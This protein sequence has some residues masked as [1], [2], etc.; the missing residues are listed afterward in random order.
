MNPAR[1]TT[2]ATATAV[3][4]ATAGTLLTL[5][6]ASA[7]TT[8]A[9]PVFKR[10]FFA[11][12]S[13]SGTPKK[14]DCDS[15]VD[16]NWGTKAPASGLPSNN[17]GVRWTVTRDFGSGGP[18]TF[19]ASGLDGIRVYLDPGTDNA[20]KIDLWKN[21]S[22]TVS[23]TVNVTVP[24]G[25]HTL[26]IDYVNW[27]GSAKV[28]FGYTP[29]TSATADKVKPLAPTG[30]SVTYDETTGEAELTWA[31]N[32]EM[33]LAGYK[34]YRRT[35]DTWTR[36][37]TTTAT[38]YTDTPPKNGDTYYYEVRA[39]DKA[40]N[41][42]AGST[43]KAVTTVKATAD[44][45]APSAPAGVEENWGVGPVDTVTLSWDGN[46]ESDLAGYRVYR[47]TSQPVVPTA[48]NLIGTPSSAS[49]ADTPARTGDWYYYVVT[50]V[51]THGNE[52]A[53]SGTAGFET[54][55]DTAPTF[56]P[57][58]LT[59]TSGDTAVT[60]TW[61]WNRDQ[62]ADLENFRV[63][64]DGAYIGD[65]TGEFVDHDVDVDATYTYY[66]RAED[67]DGNLGP[68]SASV[69]VQHLGDRTPPGAVTGLV[70]TSAENGILL[71]WDDST[72]DDF[73][74]YE[75][76][77][78]VDA[79]GVWS[80][81]TDITDSLVYG[82]TQSSNRDPN[83]PDDQNLRYAVVAVDS[84]GNALDLASAATDD[85]NEFK[86]TPD[87]MYAEETDILTVNA[88]N[89]E[90]YLNYDG[91]ADTH[92][93]AT[94]YR[95]YRWDNPSQTYVQLFDVQGTDPYWFTDSTA[96]SNSTVFYKVTALYADGT[97][98]APAGSWTFS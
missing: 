90:V 95:V 73:D 67:D 9:S 26:R 83:L 37:T 7:A 70:A 43:D 41:T 75:V 71:D 92:G 3:V 51:D 74:H 53:V 78:S 33:D 42:S 45:T 30:T 1:R 91:S 76:Y 80:P 5:T 47:S 84:D 62:D 86:M 93:T 20:R 89:G 15:A 52:S 17:F 60:L 97:E 94:G 98:S 88:A 16:Q 14:T 63:Y 11:N 56:V 96:K 82:S 29:R 55:D 79:D 32:K 81:Y 31:K 8:C 18:F 39:Y 24:K 50:A 85:V 69:T 2:T 19:S 48:E 10:Q 27:T 68:A 22:T 46:S 66:V 12:T 57:D 36:L 65:A 64:R 77:R 40:G 13:F 28:K 72:A 4:L 49:F 38:S 23:K 61:S 34:V 54:Y 59:A 25:K 21:T 6:P 35:G 44:T 87:Q 58:D